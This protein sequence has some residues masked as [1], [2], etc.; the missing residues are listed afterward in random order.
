M[1]SKLAQD[2]KRALVAETQRLTPERR[3]EAFLAHSRLL[4]ELYIAGQ[5]LRHRAAPRQEE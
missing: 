3:V 5:K 2:L 1:H 4:T